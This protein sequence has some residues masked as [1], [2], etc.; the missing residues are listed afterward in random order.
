MSRQGGLGRGLDA[1]LPA[2]AD[3][4]GGL[5]HLRLGEIVPNRRQPR[6]GFDEQGLEELAHSLRRVGML[7]PVLVRSLPDGRYELVAGERRLRAARMAG[8]EE[9]PAI[10]RTTGDGELLTEA[11][12]ENIHRVDLNPLE[13]AAALQ[14][15]LDDFGL[16]HEELATRLGK[17]R[18][19]ITNTLRLLSLTPTLQQRIANGTL[20]PGHARALLS[21]KDAAVQERLAQRVIAEGLSVR[22]TEEL[23]RKAEEAPTPSPAASR[24]RKGKSTTPPT[25]SGLE[26]VA[27]RL[28][29]ALAT[30]VRLEGS[31]ERGRIVVEFAGREDLERLLRLLSHGA[32]EDLTHEQP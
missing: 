21:V 6:G 29:D 20:S 7:Q 19:A 14:Q 2:A 5:R 24:S 3:G 25:P 11:L 13:E 1:L 27:E 22:A 8:L 16:T 31:E 9:I 28:G 10:V 30:Q 4:Q 23:A 15:L 12:V 26:H 32:G 17:S 18:P